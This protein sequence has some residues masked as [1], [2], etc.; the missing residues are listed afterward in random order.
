MQVNKKLYEL[1]NTKTLQSYISHLESAYS[2]LRVTVAM[3]R[4]WEFN[5]SLERKEFINIE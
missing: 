3:D 1:S 2:L 5:D 4:V